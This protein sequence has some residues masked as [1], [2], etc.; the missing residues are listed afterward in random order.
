MKAFF[1]VAL[2]CLVSVNAFV[3][4][5]IN[6]IDVS[7]ANVVILNAQSTS[8]TEYE[9]VAGIIRGFMNALKLGSPKDSMFCYNQDSSIALYN[10]IQGLAMVSANSNTQTIVGAVATY[11]ATIGARLSDSIN[12]STSACVA[13]SEDFAAIKAAFGT[14]PT[15]AAFASAI[16]FSLA[17]QTEVFQG[18]QNAINNA[19]KAGN[20]ETAG[21]LLA[22]YEVTIAKKIA[23]V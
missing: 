9:A 11:W 21:A 4:P 15:S 16:A 20:F 5:T 23:T 18:V 3:L 1:A 8:F 17:N 7:N 6:Q 10:Y 2:L 13:K 14:D 22:T 19:L 12:A